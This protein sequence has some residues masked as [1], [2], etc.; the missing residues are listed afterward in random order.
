MAENKYFF[1][2]KIFKRP[3]VLI[4]IL[5][6]L[7]VA[8]L[9]IFLFIFLKPAGQP[10]MKPPEAVAPKIPNII[11]PEGKVAFKYY[12]QGGNAPDFRDGSNGN[13]EVKLERKDDKV[14]LSWFEKIKI[15]TIK[16]IDIWEIWD[17]KDHKLVWGIQNYD[18]GQSSANETKLSYLTSPYELGVKPE[19]FFLLKEISQ[20]LE[21]K[22][23]RRYSIE[24]LGLNEKNLPTLG[25][26]TFDY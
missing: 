16:V 21:L 11:Y 10:E 8:G 24:L 1:Q 23:G 12:P 4:G 2:G 9:I 25:T 19:G 3:L 22:S 15:A 7:I 18:P 13:F 6:L 14:I 5:L 20:Q 26:Y 17:L